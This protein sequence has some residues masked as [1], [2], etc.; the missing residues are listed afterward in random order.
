MPV[1]DSKIS[2]NFPFLGGG[3]GLGG[4]EKIHTLYFFLLKASLLIKHCFEI[5][6]NHQANFR[7]TLEIS[8]LENSLFWTG[9]K[10]RNAKLHIFSFEV[11]QAINNGWSFVFLDLGC[12]CGC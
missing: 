5:D 6:S 7:N 4:V 1:F 12:G 8:R 10:S 2:G 11:N 3:G 9:P